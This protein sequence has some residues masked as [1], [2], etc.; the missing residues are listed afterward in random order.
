MGAWMGTPPT[1]ARID[2]AMCQNTGGTQIE[3]VRGAAPSLSP[4]PPQVMTVP[5]G[6]WEYCLPAPSWQAG[7]GTNSP[8]GRAPRAPAVVPR[9]IF[10]GAGSKHAPWQE[11]GLI[12]DVLYPCYVR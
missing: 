6:P 9:P 7:L 3:G 11:L 2:T 12:G 8:K 4:G 10:L 1:T 5:K